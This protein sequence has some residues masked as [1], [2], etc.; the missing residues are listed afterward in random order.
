MP[1]V[2]NTITINAAP[3]TVWEILGDPASAPEYVPGIVTA[4]IEGSLRVCTDADGNEIREEINLGDYSLSY[5]HLQIPLPVSQSKGKFSV[6]EQG[7]HALVEMEWEFELLDPTMESQLSPMID[8]A[9]KMTL[10]N[11]KARV[12]KDAQ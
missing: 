6:K 1:K 8:G 3:D 12:E 9:S 2:Q 10:G 7:N 11:L 5:K 4:S